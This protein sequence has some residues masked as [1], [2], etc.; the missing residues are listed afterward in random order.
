MVESGPAAGVAA[1]AYFSSLMDL[2]NVISFDMGGTTPRRA[3]SRRE[4]QV[5]S[6]FEVGQDRGREPASS[7]P[8]ATPSRFGHGSRRGRRRRR[9][10]AWIDAW[11][12]AC[13]AS[14]CR[15]HPGPAATRRAACNPRSRRESRS[16]AD[17]PDYSSARDASQREA[18]SEAIATHAARPLGMSIEE[19]HG[20]STLPMS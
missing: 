1:A 5:R 19:A 8:A 15:S 16:R 17:Q 20:M 3:S 11:F 12:D 6:E 4:P 7:R 2:R 9:Q 10:P 14:E 13:R 18:A